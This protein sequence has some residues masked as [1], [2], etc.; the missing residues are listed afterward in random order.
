M[1]IVP[2]M[3]PFLSHWKLQGPSRSA[4]LFITVG[5]VKCIFLF[6]DK[7]QSKAALVILSTVIN[8][9]QEEYIQT[10]EDNDAPPLQQVQKRGNSS[11]DVAS[12]VD[13]FLNVMNYFAWELPPDW[14]KHL[15]EKKC[16]NVPSSQ[17]HSLKHLRAVKNCV[18]IT[19]RALNSGVE[20]K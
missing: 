2:N 12:A 16:F 17:R 8:S 1:S 20:N 11:Q 18:N 6:R 13:R 4:L 9:Q 14:F 19:G 7:A 10:D 3:T 5:T 15:V